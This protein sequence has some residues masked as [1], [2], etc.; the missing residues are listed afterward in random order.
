VAS[1]LQDE[2]IARNDL[3]GTDPDEL[4]LPPNEGVRH[5]QGAQLRQRD[6]GPPLGDEPDPRIEEQRGQ[7]R[8]RF[9]LLSQRR[10]NG[11][12]GQEEQDDEAAKLRE[13]ETPERSVGVLSDDVWSDARQPASCFVGPEPCLRIDG[14]ELQD[15]RRREGVPLMTHRPVSVGGRQ[16]ACRRVWTRCV[17][18]GVLGSTRHGAGGV[19]ITSLWPDRV[20]ASRR[21]VSGCGSPRPANVFSGT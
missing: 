13:D 19:S 12:R 8:E 17:T 4:P 14:Q 3:G 6:A 16:A 9:D 20:R 10:R 5:R 21:P 7:D 15:L 2:Q 1:R 18:S 11:R